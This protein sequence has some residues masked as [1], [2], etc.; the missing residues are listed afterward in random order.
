MDVY[1]RETSCCGRYLS[2]LGMAIWFSVVTF[3]TVGY[4]D[5]AP[6]TRPGKGF[7]VLWMLVS[8]FLLSAFTGEISA[9]LTTSHFQTPQIHDLSNLG[10]LLDESGFFSLQCFS[11]TTKR[12]FLSFEWGFDF[13]S[14]TRWG[15]CCVAA[16]GSQVGVVADSVA[17]RV[18]AG[19]SSL[20]L[21]F[22]PFFNTTEAAAALAA[23]TL[24]AVFGEA[25]ALKNA[26]QLDARIAPTGH[27]TNY[28]PLVFPF[29]PGTSTSFVDQV[30]FILHAAA[31]LCFR[32]ALL[33]TNSHFVRI[34][35]L[36]LF[37]FPF[38][39]FRFGCVVCS[40]TWSCSS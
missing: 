10:M 27:L 6:V 16:K 11:F 26:A 40:S 21:N 37:H 8:L 13:L 12:V 29:A 28:R 32:F 5:V 9:A 33:Q 17:A 38:F 22:V 14:S 25:E 2:R 18:A 3:T 30:A 7:A 23:G 31:L 24:T 35:C 19:K 4:G 36:S 15:W 20:A 1:L 39:H 34:L